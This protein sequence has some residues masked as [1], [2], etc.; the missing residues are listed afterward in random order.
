[1]S[2]DLQSGFEGGCFC[3]AIRYRVS[4]APYFVYLCH[5]SDC[6]RINGSAFHTGIAVPLA[7]LDVT[8]GTPDTFETTADSGNTITRYHCAHCATQLWSITTA[9]NTLVSVKAGSVTSVP[10]DAIRPMMQ[11][12]WDSR[13]AWAPVEANITTYARGLRGATPIRP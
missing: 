12:F 4:A 1:M 9:D 8:S 2:E 10:A 7:S 6:R 3:G 11:I 13:V 5:C